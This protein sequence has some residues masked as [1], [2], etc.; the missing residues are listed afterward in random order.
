MLALVRSIVLELKWSI[1]AAVPPRLSL[2]GF[3]FAQPFF[4]DRLIQ[5]VSKGGEELG[6]AKYGLIGAAGLIYVGLALSNALYK[7]QAVR[8][9]TM[10][11]G[12]L[13]G[14]IYAETLQQVSQA[15]HEVSSVTLMGTDVDRI[16]TGVLNCHELWASSL[17]VM[18][19]FALLYKAIGYASV[20]ALFFA[21]S[22]LCLLRMSRCHV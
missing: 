20:A 9:V 16:V 14:T 8:L 1:A 15:G 3:K 22:K 13:V 4:I 19:A 11:R 12:C 7:R 17:E 10:V 2:I 6:G 21:C 18:I 5:Y